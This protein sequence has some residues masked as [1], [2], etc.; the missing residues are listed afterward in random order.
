[1][2]LIYAGARFAELGHIIYIFNRFFVYA[3]TRYVARSPSVCVCLCVYS[4]CAKMVLANAFA[5]LKR[6]YVM[7]VP[8]N[9]LIIVSLYVCVRAEIW[10]TSGTATR[11]RSCCEKYDLCDVRVGDLICD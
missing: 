7:S 1:M 10:N 5:Y 11:V 2:H 8:A 3:R 6:V 9:F 4:L